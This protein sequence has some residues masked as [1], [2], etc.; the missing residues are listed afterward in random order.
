M[1][2]LP[3]N[4]LATILRDYAH[5]RCEMVMTPNLNLTNSIV[6]WI[7]ID[8][9]KSLSEKQQCMNYEYLMSVYRI[10]LMYTTLKYFSI[11]E[12][13]SINFI[14]EEELQF[15]ISKITTDKN[16]SKKKLLLYMRNA[17]N[18]NNDPNHSKYNISPNGKYLEIHLLDIRSSKE[19][20]ME[21]SKPKPFYIK[22]EF[23]QLSE[24]VVSMLNASRGLIVQEWI[25]PSEFDITNLTFDMLKNVSTKIYYLKNKI[26]DNIKTLRNQSVDEGIRT[27]EE[28][29]KVLNSNSYLITEHKLYDEQI[30][31]ILEEFN[32]YQ[33]KFP[34]F[35]KDEIYQSVFFRKLLEQTEPLPTYKTHIL[36]FQGLLHQIY[37]LEPSITQ[38]FIDKQ[39]TSL[40]VGEEILDTNNDYK[41]FDIKRRKM[42]KDVYLKN[43]TTKINL[44]IKVLDKNSQIFYPFMMY[45]GYMIDTIIKEETL[46]IN[47]TKYSREKLR[48]AIVHGRY[49]ISNNGTIHFYDRNNGYGLDHNFNAHY[50]ILFSD[51]NDFVEEKYNLL[52]NYRND[53]N[54]LKK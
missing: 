27:K 49:I 36:Q 47:N 37:M 8:N 25:K 3:K 38:N 40:L 9:T 35:K 30:E 33:T 5:I 19:K 4:N 15:D 53:I 32:F 41:Q 54:N 10:Y 22:I 13:N 6:R 11:I 14:S 16:I 50:K 1:I 17:F 26:D 34:N 39:L 51:L 2:S 44:A 52:V 28:K 31:K 23:Q 21:N 20:L 12:E 43:L 18:H 46:I 29:E 48:N 7:N 24:I 42:V 45:F